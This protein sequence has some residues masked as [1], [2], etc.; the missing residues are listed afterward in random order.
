MS[1]V[2]LFNLN[3]SGRIYHLRQ[4]RTWKEKVQLAD[5]FRNAFTTLKPHVGTECMVVRKKGRWPSPWA[6]E[7][8]K[9]WLH[10]QLRTRWGSRDAGLGAI[11]LT[12]TGGL[13][14]S[15]REKRKHLPRGWISRNTP[16]SR[17]SRTNPVRVIS[18]LSEVPSR[19]IP[20]GSFVGTSLN[21]WKLYLGEKTGE[22][23][24]EHFGKQKWWEETSTL[25]DIKSML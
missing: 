6:P 16:G 15:L 9:K 2:N 21:V 23:S 7:M 11:S 4:E 3:P 20:M 8:Q 10:S 18:R 1:Q 22:K 12:S 17:W 24:W 19:A 13:G 14:A 25:P 5:D